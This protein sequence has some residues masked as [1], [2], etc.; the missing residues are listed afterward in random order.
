MIMK[1]MK[2]LM[3]DNFRLATEILSKYNQEHLLSF[4]DELEENQKDMLINQI[5]RIDF[6]NILTL[7]KNSFIDSDSDIKD[8]SPLLH[9][10]KENLTTKEIERYTNIGIDSIKKG[11]FAVITLSGGQR[12]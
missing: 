9:I 4:Y 7:Y 11:E 3:N 6:D 12:N 10:D 8:I 5:L 1:G 2:V